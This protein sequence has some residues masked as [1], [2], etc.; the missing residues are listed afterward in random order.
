MHPFVYEYRKVRNFKT[1]FIAAV[2]VFFS[3]DDLVSMVSDFAQH[4]ASAHGE[5]ISDAK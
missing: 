5:L 1:P 2:V 3:R 4:N